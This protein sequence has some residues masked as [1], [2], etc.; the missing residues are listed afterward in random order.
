MTAMLRNL[1]SIPPNF[2]TIP[3]NSSTMLCSLLM[4]K[5]RQTIKEDRG[6][7]ASVVVSWNFGISDRQFLEAADNEMLPENQWSPSQSRIV[8]VD[9][10]VV[11]NWSSSF[12]PVIVYVDIS[13]DGRPMKLLLTGERLR[14]CICCR[15][16]AEV[17]ADRKSSTSMLS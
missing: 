4:T 5:W 14:R 1:S 16:L 17:I 9:D 15:K 2:P 8:D 3:W 6:S 11:G 10:N 13:V 7:S 12:R